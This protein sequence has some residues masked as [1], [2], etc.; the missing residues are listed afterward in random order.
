[1]ILFI[2]L[3]MKTHLGSPVRR[4]CLGGRHA[5]DQRHYSHLG[6]VIVRMMVMVIVMVRMT[7]VM[8]VMV[9]MIMS[10]MAM[11]RISMMVMSRMMLRMMVM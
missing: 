3:T 4:R 9:I 7:M 1:M 11:L 5:G 6:I 10:M 8:I 2:I